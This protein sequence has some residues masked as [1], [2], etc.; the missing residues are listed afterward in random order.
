MGDIYLSEHTLQQLKEKAKDGDKKAITSLGEFFAIRDNYEKDMDE[1][2]QWLFL[3]A[4]QGHILSQKTLGVLYYGGYCDE[5]GNRHDESFRWFKMAADQGDSTSLWY[6]SKFYECGYGSIDKDLD[7][8]MEIKIKSNLIRYDNLSKGEAV[9][10]TAGDISLDKAFTYVEKAKKMLHLGENELAL[11]SIRNALEVTIKQLCVAASIDYDTR[12]ATLETLIN[13]LAANVS[14]LKD[15]IP[16]M[17]AIRIECN[18]AAHADI[19]SL[20]V[21]AENA[22]RTVERMEALLSSVS[23][24]NLSALQENM[25]LN[26]KP[27][28]NPDYYS[29]SRP[30]YGLWSHCMTREELMVIPEYVSLYQKATKNDD[31]EAMLNIAVGFLPRKIEWG[32]HGLVD[33][34]S[35]KHKGKY[36]KNDNAYDIRYYYWIATAI[37]AAVWS[38]R[39][40]PLKYIGTAFWE[41]SLL[42]FYTLCSKTYRMYVS[43]VR[44]VDGMTETI[45]GDQLILC[46]DMFGKTGP[47]RSSFYQKDILEALPSVGSSHLV[48][49]LYSSEGVVAPIFIN[50]EP[51][52]AAKIRI[53]NF[54]PRC[55]GLIEKK[56]GGAIY[57]D[58]EINYSYK[59]LTGTNLPDKIEAIYIVETFGQID[60]FKPYCEHILNEYREE[61]ATFKKEEEKRARK[62]RTKA[63]FN[64]L[65]KKK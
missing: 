55:A 49:G 38:G 37:Y 23:S 33:M 46:K 27:M 43:D 3:A 60:F 31:I 65:I 58:A 36:Y 7:K 10:G 42:R 57:I 22:S 51:H 52:T 28:I 64:N 29:K 45:Y 13:E 11:S 40:V 54:L 1:A 6:L 59:T 34:P 62:E 9:D 15:S 5:Y 20:G 50:A 26:N 12:K 53:L 30:Y 35:V 39:T 8:A 63:F 21:S 32:S 19:D 44:E 48:D 17:H 4:E 2:L 14:L 41:Y 25:V 18:K 47:G 56:P 24:V 16:T 61:I